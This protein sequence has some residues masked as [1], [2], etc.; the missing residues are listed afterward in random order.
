MDD[1][2]QL[3]TCWPF[4]EL[5]SLLLEVRRDK[6]IDD[7]ERQLLLTFFSEWTT[8][9]GNRSL[10]IPLNEVNVPIT[11]LCAVC[12]E[13]DLEERVFCFTG[14]S[15]KATRKQ[16]QKIV[17]D[18]GGTFHPRVTKDLDYLVIGGD[19]NPCW[20]FACYGRKVE[21]AVALRKEGA[22]LLLVHEADFWDAIA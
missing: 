6:K 9:R 21:Q 20:A 14:A 1:N 16:F 13:V 15:L 18:K 17:E 3:R 22:K 19:G 5:E 10:N 11:G 7:R 4:A 2:E 12:P 8:I